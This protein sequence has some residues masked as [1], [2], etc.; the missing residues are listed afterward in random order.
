MQNYCDKCLLK[1]LDEMTKINKQLK[2]VGKKNGP[3]KEQ[4][5]KMKKEIFKQN[6]NI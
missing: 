2:N 3:T 1:I 6:A 5:K 4:R